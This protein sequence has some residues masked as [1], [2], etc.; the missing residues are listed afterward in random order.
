MVGGHDFADTIGDAAR[1]VFLRLREN[2][3]E[4][5]A[6]VS[7]GGIDGAAVNAEN[8]GEAADGAAADE[9]AGTIVDYLQAVEIKQQ[10]GEVP[11]GAI[12][13]LPLALKNIEQAAGTGWAVERITDGPM[14]NLLETPRG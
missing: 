6:A 4:F 8:I 5:V 10:H 3:G 1:F 13:G 9:M 12:G 11:A 7:R 2:Q 14:V